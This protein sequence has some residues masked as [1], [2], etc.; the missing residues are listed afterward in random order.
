MTARQGSATIRRYADLAAQPW[1]N[2]LGV[3]RELHVEPAAEGFRWRLSMAEI[4]APAAFSAYPGIDRVFA[5]LAGGGL[6]LTVD[7][8]ATQL[9]VGDIATFA[10]EAAVVATPVAGSGTDLNLMLARDDVDGSLRLVAIDGT[11]VW[12]DPAVVAVVVVAGSARHGEATLG[13]LDTLLI[14]SSPV[15]LTGQAT[16]IEVRV[17]ATH[18]P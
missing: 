1:R 4:T 2:G 16:L 6:V 12:S 5:V 9:S 11:A 13:R 17:L 7:G 10:G 3:T 14:A 15:S 8:V 18:L